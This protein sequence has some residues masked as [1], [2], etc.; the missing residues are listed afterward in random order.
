MWGYRPVQGVRGNGGFRIQILIALVLC[1]GA[2]HAQNC[3]PAPSGLVSWWPGNGSANDLLGANSG[4]IT[5]QFLGQVLFTEGKVGTA[6]DFRGTNFV[7]IPPIALNS[8]TLEFWLDQRTRGSEPEVG[9]ILVSGEV[10]GVVD[11]WGVSILPDG[12]LRVQIG[13][14]IQGTT[15]YPTSVSSIPLNTFTHVAVTRNTSTNEIKIYING[16]LDSSH[17]S[18]H[19]RVLG[20]M[21]PTCDTNLHQNRIGIGNLRRQAILGG[22][23]QAFDGLID[24]VSLYNRPLSGD[25]IAAIYGAGNAGKC[26]AQEPAPCVAAPPG[27]VSWWRANGDGTDAVGS[28]NS[29]LMNA[30]SFSDGKVGQV[31]TFNGSDSQARFGNIIGNFGTNDFTIEFWLR[32][33]ASRLESLIEKYPTCGPASEWYIRLNN[34]KLGAEMMSDTVFSDHNV[35]VSQRSINDGLFHHIAFLRRETNVAFYI[36]G[37]LDASSNST[38]G[39]T[40]LN[41]NTDFVAGR[42]VCVGVGGTSPFTGQLDELSVYGRALS[43]SEIQEIYQ[44]GSG[45]KCSPVPEPHCDPAPSG[46][47]S[48][49]QAEGNANDSMNGNQGV[50]VNGASFAPGEVG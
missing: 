45:G 35:V 44:A 48:W 17:I 8:F 32:T 1:T 23:A 28:N 21:D 11:D 3:A 13:D 15:F 6:F 50:L 38:G 42:S 43:A 37:A 19:N 34:G 20:T 18:P 4:T 39:I 46:L 41:N 12:R 5:T 9:S 24:E 40:R 7:E 47:V 33:T 49:W 2:L 30:V 25:E 26:P 14:A 29:T 22:N 31:F 10:C 16:V 36:D 27:L